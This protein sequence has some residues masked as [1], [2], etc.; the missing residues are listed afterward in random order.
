MLNQAL[1]MTQNGVMC[2][3][4]PT[5]GKGG[6]VNNGKFDCHL[7][8]KSDQS[9]ELVHKGASQFCLQYIQFIPPKTKARFRGYTAKHLKI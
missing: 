4:S 1:R 5:A 8:K 9:D 3:K 2:S 6:F 7:A